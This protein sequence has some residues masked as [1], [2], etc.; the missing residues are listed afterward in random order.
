[1]E[2]IDIIKLMIQEKQEQ[3]KAQTNFEE[4]K[5][6]K[7]LHNYYDEYLH[8]NL[9]NLAKDGVISYNLNSKD[10]EEREQAQDIKHFV[11]HTIQNIIKYSNTNFNELNEKDLQVF[12]YLKSQNS[13]RDD[14]YSETILNDFY[15][16]KGKDNLDL[17]ETKDKDYKKAVAN[18]ICNVLIARTNT[19]LIKDF[20]KDYVFSTLKDLYKENEIDFD[21]TK[22]DERTKKIKDNILTT[23]TS[24]IIE[25]TWI[26]ERIDIQQK[27]LPI[28]NFICSDDK[29]IK[30]AMAMYFINQF[31]VIYETK[32]FQDY[33][34]S[35]KKGA[36]DINVMTEKELKKHN[37][38]ITKYEMIKDRTKEIML[39]GVFNAL[40]ILNNEKTIIFDMSSNNKRIQ[41]ISK[42]IITFITKLFQTM[43]LTYLAD[44]ENNNNKT[45]GF[46]KYLF[47]ENNT[48]NS[49]KKKELLTK[50]MNMFLHYY[51]NIDFEDDDYINNLNIYL[52]SSKESTEEKER[53]RIIEM[54]KD[55]KD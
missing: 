2:K 6:I 29:E 52:Y 25:L 47:I 13:M 8:Y 46:M 37:E 21:I 23:L 49:D 4:E 40:N 5:Y 31:M 9:L 28:F 48:Q 3:E 53:E 30:Q 32:E 36:Y 12:D 41:K 10:D 1:M 15:Q 45:I 42:N 27:D 39:C 44:E 18:G 33:L 54:L 43:A 11:L 55:K 26:T 7:L 24:F 19:K 20:Y 14:F 16:R 38:L 34:K 51:P 35:N 17:L 22:D 50:I